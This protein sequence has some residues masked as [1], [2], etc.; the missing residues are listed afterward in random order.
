MFMC[1]CESR[2]GGICENCGYKG[3]KENIKEKLQK[4]KIFFLGG[5]EEI[6]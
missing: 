5:K 2:G 1:V 4:S 3:D 6:Y